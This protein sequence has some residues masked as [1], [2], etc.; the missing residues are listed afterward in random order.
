M[1]NLRAGLFGSCCEPSVSGLSVRSLS[2]SHPLPH[3]LLIPQVRGPVPAEAPRVHGLQQ[4]RLPL[5][6]GSQQVAG[7]PH[8]KC[9]PHW[10]SWGGGPVR[11]VEL[12]QGANIDGF[13]IEE[14]RADDGGPEPSC[15]PALIVLAH[16]TC[17]CT[18]RILG[19]FQ[20]QGEWGCAGCR[21]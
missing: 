18:P 17:I 10:R 2:K 21:H 5:P 3:I 4:H 7:S 13:R 9:H 20:E 14:G 19:V 15:S 11:S 8:G 1:V 12:E 6:H 16:L